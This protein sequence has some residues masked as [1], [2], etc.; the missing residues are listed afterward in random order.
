MKSEGKFIVLDGTDGAGKTVQLELLRKK[1]S[2]QGFNFSVLD[3]PRY[4]QKS[5][6]L[7]EEYLN[8]RYGPAEEVGPYRASIFYAADRYAA[9]FGLKK[10]LSEGKIVISNRYVSANMGHQGGKIKDKKERDKYFQWLYDLEYNLFGIPKPDLN[11]I[12]WMPAGIA[13]ELVGKKEKRGYLGNKKRDLHEENLEHL[14][15]TEAVFLEMADN[16]PGFAVIKCVDD[17]NN[18][19]EPEKIHQSVWNEVNLIL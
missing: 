2:E 13:Y 6:G 16:F 12:L 14:K 15:N 17:E 1:L 3:F 18:L 4:G 5:A 11:I 8:G 9:S 19:L 10:D 7:V